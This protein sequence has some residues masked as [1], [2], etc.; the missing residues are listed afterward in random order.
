MT[1]ALGN[2]LAWKF[3]V[4]ADSMCLFTLPQMSSDEL[5]SFVVHH[6]EVLTSAGRSAGA[7]P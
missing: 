6:F 7:V 3:L 4:M 5:L 2:R 1:A